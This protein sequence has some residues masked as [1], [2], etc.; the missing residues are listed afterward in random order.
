LATEGV[1]QVIGVAIE[2]YLKKELIIEVQMLYLADVLL[3]LTV[4][5]SLLVLLN[6]CRKSWIIRLLTLQL[7]PFWLSSPLTLWLTLITP[8]KMAFSDT[9]TAFGWV[10]MSSCM[11]RL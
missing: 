10:L 3:Y 7:R 4:L 2:D 11:L 6:G 1:Y 5:S 9:R 8:C